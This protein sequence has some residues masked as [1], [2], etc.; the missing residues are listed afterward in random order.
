MIETRDVVEYAR[1]IFARSKGQPDKR[2]MHSRRDWLFVSI[3][4]LSIF[5]LGV[6]AGLLQYQYVRELPTTVSGIHDMNVPRYQQSLVTNVHDFYAERERRY[7]EL[8][9]QSATSQ[10][11]LEEPDSLDGEL[12]FDSATTTEEVGDSE[13]TEVFLDFLPI[14]TEE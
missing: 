5:L 11:L 2:I 13:D 8:Q 14:S 3:V 1:H 6:A 4:F 12:E 7:L 10:V 9:A